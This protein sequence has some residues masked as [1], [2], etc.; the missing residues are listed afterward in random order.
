MQHHIRELESTGEASFPPKAET[1]DSYNIREM[2][3]MFVDKCGW[4]AFPHPN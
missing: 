2:E 1:T 4:L 3:G